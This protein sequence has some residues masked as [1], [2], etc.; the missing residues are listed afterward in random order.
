M[1]KWEFT[2]GKTA[3]NSI[4]LRVELEKK[5]CT[6]CYI[7]GT[8]HYLLQ[9]NVILWISVECE[10]GWKAERSGGWKSLA[11]NSIL[12][13]QSWTKISPLLQVCVPCTNV[14]IDASMV[15]IN[16]S[17]LLMTTELK[18][19]I[20][21]SKEY[22]CAHRA[23]GKMDKWDNSPNTACGKTRSISPDSW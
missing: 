10:G 9:I 23:D 19:M 13:P 16:L 1:T 17:S 3:P 11:G 5:N 14:Q 22:Y 20:Y 7:G 12:F 21:Q 8:I 18:P 15:A 4:T 6:D 2:D